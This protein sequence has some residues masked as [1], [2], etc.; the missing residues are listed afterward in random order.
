[1]V[2]KIVKREWARPSQSS[3]I[4]A[5]PLMM[6]I[7]QKFA[8]VQMNSHEWLWWTVIP[9]LFILWFAIN[10]KIKKYENKH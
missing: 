10:F 6:Y 2:I 7:M 8:S 1:M 4:W 9:A 3:T 5:I